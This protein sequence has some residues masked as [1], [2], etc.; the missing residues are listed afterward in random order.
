MKIK[1]AKK[2]KAG[3][4]GDLPIK[5]YKQ[6]SEELAITEA[7]VFNKIV[8]TCEWPTRWKIENGIP[9]NKVTQKQPES[10][11]HLRVISLTPFLSKTFERIVFDWLVHYVGNKLD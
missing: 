9:L 11:S 8:Q 1:I 4:Q 2:T 3:V 5:L 10:E 6:F 7:I